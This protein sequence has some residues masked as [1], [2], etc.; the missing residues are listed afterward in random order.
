MNKTRTTSHNAALD[1]LR[2]ISFLWVY[3][4]HC[5]M[6]PQGSY[7]VT[8][9]YVISGFLIG[10]ILIVQ[11]DTNAPL[12]RR[13]RNFYIRRALR[14]FPLYYAVL[15]FLVLMSICH[16]DHNMGFYW[17]EAAYLTNF[18]LVSGAPLS[19]GSHFWT[20]AIEEQFYLIAPLMIL[21]LPLRQLQWCLAA[22][23]ISSALLIILN[24]VTIHANALYFSSPIQFCY[25][26]IGVATAVC[27]T[28]GRFMS[29]NRTGFE[30]IGLIAGGIVLFCFLPPIFYSLRMQLSDIFPVLVALTSA[31]LILRLWR[32]DRWL[33]SRLLAV[34][35]LAYLGR[36]SYGLYIFHILV[37]DRVPSDHRH[38]R[39]I[40][41]L[42]I[43]VAISALSWRLFENPINRL[44]ERFAP[45]DSKPI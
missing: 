18:W 36:I 44:K 30:R 17:C 19:E 33:V 15:A 5:G 27:D 20:L 8:V 35:P 25:L 29:L 40:S 38:H 3:F 21:V 7:G 31:G 2:F 12:K 11:R 23:W 10:R 6:F 24:P 45:S 39:V 28:Q 43:T 41:S 22:L 32:D 4:Y 9:F 14:I 1:G 13:L 34:K 26:G 16:H 42:L 37:L